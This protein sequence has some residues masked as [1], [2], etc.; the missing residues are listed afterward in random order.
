[1]VFF[2]GFMKTYVKSLYDCKDI[3]VKINDLDI[4]NGGD[5]FPLDEA[6]DVV[7]SHIALPDNSLE[8]NTFSKQSMQDFIKTIINCIYNAGH[9]N[10]EHIATKPYVTFAIDKKNYGKKRC[11]LEISNTIFNKLYGFDIFT[12]IDRTKAV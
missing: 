6:M 9:L 12:V 1:M 8:N 10:N 3:W 2:N 5:D 11:M 7:F 4:R